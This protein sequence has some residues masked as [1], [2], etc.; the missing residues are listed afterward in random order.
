M[1]LLFASWERLLHYGKCDDSDV[2]QSV[3]CVTLYIH[4]QNTLSASILIADFVVSISH[5]K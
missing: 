4:C 5:E 3:M 1:C 2:C